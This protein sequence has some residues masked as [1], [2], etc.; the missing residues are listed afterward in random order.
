MENQII[1]RLYA[2]I[3]CDIK[4]QCWN[5]TGPLNEHGYGRIS[6]NSKNTYIHRIMYQ[7]FYGDIP[8]DKPLVLHT[9][10]NPKCCNPKHLYAGTQ[11]DN[12]QDRVKRNPDSWSKKTGRMGE[13]NHAAKLTEKQVIEIRTSQETQNTIAKRFNVGRTII[14]LIKNRKTWKHI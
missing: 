6:M 4:T 1:K 7:Y 10:D 9:C 11:K 3:V 12:A 2:K 14:S 5:W 8:E 13:K